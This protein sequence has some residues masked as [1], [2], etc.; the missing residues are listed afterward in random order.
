MRRLIPDRFE[1]RALGRSIF[2]ALAL[3]SIAAGPVSAQHAAGHPGAPGRTS[4]PPVAPH[5]VAPFRPPASVPSPRSFVVRPYG[6]R[7]PVAPGFR[8][9]YP[10]RPIRP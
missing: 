1:F 6:I 3:T 9:G 4:A 8:A 5:P 2:V 7:T 10:Y